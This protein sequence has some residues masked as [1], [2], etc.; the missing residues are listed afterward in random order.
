MPESQAPIE[1][2]KTTMANPRDR[3]TKVIN[4]IHRRIFTLTKG[5]LGGTLGGMPIV[6]LTTTGRKSG[7]SHQTMVGAPIID[8]GRLILVASFGG[9]PNHPQWYLNLA[10]NGHAVVTLRG[11]T[12]EMKARVAEGP[13][14][15]ELWRRLDEVTPAFEKYR[16]LTTREIPIVVL[17]P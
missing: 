5:R 1:Q 3:I 10:A 12:T 8:G 6:L 11:H 17:E 2:V 7:R 13:E 15:E 16:G 9:Q 14:R 4:K